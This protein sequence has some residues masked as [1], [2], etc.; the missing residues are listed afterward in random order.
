MTRRYRWRG[1]GDDAVL[2][3]DAVTKLVD[4]LIGTA[5]VRTL[6]VFRTD[7]RQGVVT[8]AAR[9]PMFWHR[10]LVAQAG[11]F[12]QRRLCCRRRISR[13]S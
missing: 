2:V 11:R 8:L 6:D 5:T 7:W 10:V 3:E 12:S 4:R 1:T 13:S 9:R